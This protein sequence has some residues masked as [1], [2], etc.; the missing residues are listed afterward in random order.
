MGIF[1]TQLFGKGDDDDEWGGGGGEERGSYTLKG[2]LTATW[3]G[4][5]VGRGCGGVG[6]SVEGRWS[7]EHVD[8]PLKGRGLRLHNLFPLSSHWGS[9]NYPLLSPPLPEHQE[10]LSFGNRPAHSQ[11][12]SIGNEISDI[13]HAPIDGEFGIIGEMA[14]PL[15]RWL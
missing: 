11:D 6:L 8:H 3:K 13:K 1:P 10:K 2:S 12:G 7:P 15:L 9:I 5:G 4:G 14:S